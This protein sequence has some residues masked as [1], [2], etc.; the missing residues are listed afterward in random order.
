M[1]LNLG[2]KVMVDTICNIDG[3]RFKSIE[4]V[5]VAK[6]TI[7]TYHGRETNYDI[8]TTNGKLHCILRYFITKL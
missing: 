7:K 1:E 3:S 4:G 2:Q 8:E 6:R 5:I